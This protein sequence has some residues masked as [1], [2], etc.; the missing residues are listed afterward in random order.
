MRICGSAVVRNE[1]DLIEAFVRHNLTVLD[2][3]VIVDHMS[4]D[5]TYEILQAM[6]GEGL[7]L[8]LARE[9]SKVFDQFGICNRLV[10]HIFA[11]SDVDWVFPLDA[12]EFVKT[13]SRRAL[14]ASL[15]ADPAAPGVT[16]EWLTY[17][18]T[19]FANDALSTLRSA[20]RVPTERHG[21]AK[22]AVSRQFAGAIDLAIANGHHHL[23]RGDPKHDARQVPPPL[24]PDVAA[25]A[26]VPI[27]SVRQF[28]AKIALG[29]LSS[30]KTL[31]H[32]KSEAFHWREA[33]DYLRSGRP[34]S[35]LQLKAFA[36]NYS[37][38]MDRWLPVDSV[39]LVEDPFLA[40]IRLRHA[41]RGIDDP[42]A[43]VL[44]YAESLIVR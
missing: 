28:T 15:A 10:R 6:A 36:V 23:L 34:L 7:P 8:F 39:E 5:G 43:L 24:S 22:I 1:A 14:E 12:D 29:W 42:L 40:D 31:D 38:P 20:R 17:V 37:I 26:H 19:V 3:M 30:L 33:F 21:L 32:A 13:P 11:T 18:P 25:I 2:G 4:Q 27:R 16:L 44:A 35:P 41:H 9:T